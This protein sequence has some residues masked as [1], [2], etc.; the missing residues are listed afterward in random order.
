MLSHPAV[1]GA[2]QVAHLLGLLKHVAGDTF[3]TQLSKSQVCQQLSP[4]MQLGAQ[5]VELPSATYVKAPAATAAARARKPR[6][7]MVPARAS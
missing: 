6:R 7:L 5:A 4:A 1:E 2:P 3:L